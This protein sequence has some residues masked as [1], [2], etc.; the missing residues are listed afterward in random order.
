MKRR[1][2]QTCTPLGFNILCISCAD[3]E[4]FVWVGG[5]RGGGGQTLIFF[6]LFFNKSEPS[7]APAKRHLN[8]VSL[9]GR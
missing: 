5:G 3:S 9:A 2:N 6:V 8:G 7:S 1:E 4:S